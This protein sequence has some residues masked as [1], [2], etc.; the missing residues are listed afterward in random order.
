MIIIIILSALFIFSLVRSILG[1]WASELV[2]IILG[3]CLIVLVCGILFGIP[4]E[5][6]KFKL[7][8]N[9]TVMYME[10]CRANPGLTGAEAVY[11][12][13]LIK[14]VNETI[15]LHRT[16]SKNSLY[17]L[18]YSKKTGDIKLISF[19]DIPVANTITNL[20]ADVQIVPE[21]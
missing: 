1:Y 16:F 19:K 9:Q 6:T 13:K 15:M 7:E 11:A 10:S 12:A 2:C 4:A 5:H 17:G 8:Y 3:V 20:S 21:F 14:Q 18:F